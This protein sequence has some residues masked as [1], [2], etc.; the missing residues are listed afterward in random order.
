MRYEKLWLYILLSLFI[1][2]TILG[3]DL[4]MRGVYRNS[5]V[6]MEQGTSC[7]E[8]ELRGAIESAE[9]QSSQEKP[10]DA[11][12]KEPLEHALP[13][14]KED[15]DEKAVFEREGKDALRA[16]D[17]AILNKI[18]ENK[19]EMDI[20]DEDGR[21]M[22][23]AEKRHEKKLSHD[24]KNS[25]APNK[26]KSDDRERKQSSHASSGMLGDIHTKG[27]PSAK[28]AGIGKPKYPKECL[29]KGHEGRVVIE[30]TIKADGTNG[31]MVLIE[32]SGCE[33]MDKS[34]LTFLKK[35]T[36]IPKM[37]MGVPVHSKKKMAFR[38][39]ITEAGNSE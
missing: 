23:E 17:P 18:P 30:I 9:I 3:A 37:V 28:V 12:K 24:S 34:P 33:Y 14:Y 26:E 15:T 10:S 27:S 7:I 19:T 31:G 8:L 21:G 29:L 1:H 32:S 4:C 5:L 39:K 6:V 36:L 25:T 22:P 11:E 38:F 20:S 35:C 13:S 16:E 2:A